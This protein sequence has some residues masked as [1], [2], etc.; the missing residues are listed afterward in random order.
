MLY[1]S[2]TKL[3][4]I[5]SIIIIFSFFT[6]TNFIE[7]KDNFILSKK[8]NLGL[9][10]QG[11]SYLLL[12]VDSAPII[13]QNLQQKLIN[14]VK[15]LKKEKI[16]FQ[17]MKISDQSINFSLNN[18]DI[19][20]FEKFFLDKENTINNYYNQYRS[21]EMNYSIDNKQ[22]KINYSK[23]GLIEIKKNTLDQLNFIL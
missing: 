23:F 20:K 18:N 22:I 2:K 14:L 19:E 3:F 9:D 10:L 16:K 17:G 12:E 21:Y 13:K 7:N 6:F 15:Y 1:F 4:I 11:G 8:I 5:Y